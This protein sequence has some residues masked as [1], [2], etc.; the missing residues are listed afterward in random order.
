MNRA[1]KQTVTAIIGIIIGF[2]GGRL[3]QQKIDSKAVQKPDKIYYYGIDGGIEVELVGF[4]DYREFEMAAKKTPFLAGSEKRDITDDYYITGDI[5]LFSDV[6]YYGEDSSVKIVL[7]TE[8]GQKAEDFTL[9][10][11]G[12]SDVPIKELPFDM[13]GAVT[14]EIQKCIITIDGKDHIV[15]LE[16]MERYM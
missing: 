11:M 6:E 14:G 13:T 1:L 4:R 12:K 15:D 2:G 7:E 8:D 9:P 3:I 10:Y 16:I 5:R